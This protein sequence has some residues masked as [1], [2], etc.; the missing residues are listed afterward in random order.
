MADEAVKTAGNVQRVVVCRRSGVADV[1]FVR[2]RDLW[3]HEL[4]SSQQSECESEWMDAEA[5]ALLLYTS[6]TTAKPKGTVI[7]H[8]GALLQ[9]SKEVYFNLDLKDGDVFFW[10]SDIG[11][12]MGPWQITGVQHL[13]GTHLIFDGVPDYPEPDRLWSMIEKL[14]IT[15]LGGSATV[16]RMLK[17]YGHEQVKAHDLSSLR[18]LGNTGEIIDPDTWMWLHKTVGGKRCPIINLAGGTEIFGC[19]LLP[20]PIM[21]LK[22]STLGGPGL[23]MDIDVFDEDGKPVRGEVGYL[24]CKKPAPSMTRGFWKDPQRYIE[25]YWSRWPG[26]WF[27]GDYAFVD[28]DGYW[29]LR[30]RADDMIKVAGKRMGPAEIESILNQ[31][32]AVYES[33][34]VG[35]PSEVKGEEIVVFAVLKPGYTPSH[36]LREMLMEEVVK[37][38][39]KPFKPRDIIFVG[40]LP[41]TRSGKILRRLIKSA[42][43]GKEP[44]D[45]SALENPK[46]LQEI[47]RTT[48]S[49]K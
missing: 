1:S 27:H 20:L 21:P 13:G 44:G 30:G 22:P 5:P 31:H 23:G 14:H 18:M 37:K 4:V 29:F 40:D 11:W 8:A 10:I 3:W 42:V 12:M 39:G 38:M 32:S 9:S 47:T 16:Y 15:T 34:C 43:M 7:S 24:V 33:A 19:L 35:L 49:D 25:T 2:G 48:K 46:A 6:G 36:K 45:T 26:V 41:R 17:K 28:E